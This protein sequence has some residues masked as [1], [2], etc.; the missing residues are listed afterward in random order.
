[1]ATLSSARTLN[2]KGHGTEEEGEEGKGCTRRVFIRAEASRRDI[3]QQGAQIVGGSSFRVKRVVGG[4]LIT[5]FEIYILKES[6]RGG[7]GGVWR[8]ITRDIDRKRIFA[9]AKSRKSKSPYCG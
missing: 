2:G 3:R 9:A 6:M 1:M 5:V 8:A 7:E 4:V